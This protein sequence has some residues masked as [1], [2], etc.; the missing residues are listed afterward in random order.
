MKGTP[1]LLAVV[2]G[3]RGR[4]DRG[5][6]RTTNG[7]DGLTMP[8]PVRA[9][10]ADF[11]KEQNSSDHGFAEFC[12]APAS[13]PASDPARS[14]QGAELR[15]RARG[16][17][18]FF[19]AS[20]DHGQGCGNRVQLGVHRVQSGIRSRPQA[21]RLPH[22]VCRVARKSRLAR[23][24]SRRPQS[25]SSEDRFRPWQSVQCRVHLPSWGE[26]NA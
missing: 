7:R 3:L 24:Q 2:S 8:C 16:R 10:Q 5:R 17:I 4:P 13:M 18:L 26:R 9:G 1:A 12:S 20:G 6:K 15:I 23:Q 21:R 25:S 22:S 19:L 11:P 14:G